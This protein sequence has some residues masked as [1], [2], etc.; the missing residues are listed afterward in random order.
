[1]AEATVVI[2]RR[3]GGMYLATSL[4]GRCVILLE[5][6]SGAGPRNDGCGRAVTENEGVGANV[7]VADV[8][9]EAGML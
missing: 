5:T 1:M 7:E 4:V 3:L 9:D 6:T 8:V 2:R